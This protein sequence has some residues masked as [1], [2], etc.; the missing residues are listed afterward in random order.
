M[1][2][3]NELRQETFGLHKTSGLSFDNL[4][5]FT[6]DGRKDSESRH[7]HR[8]LVVTV[9]YNRCSILLFLSFRHFSPR[10]V[11]EFFPS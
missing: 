1:F 3:L 9:F 8:I 5:I 10:L 6:V 7:F 2:S 11:L 4:S